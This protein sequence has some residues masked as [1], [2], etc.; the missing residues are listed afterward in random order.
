MNLGENEYKKNIPIRKTENGERNKN[1][2]IIV[3]GRKS[4][5][6]LII[7]LENRLISQWNTQEMYKGGRMRKSWVSGVEIF[8]IEVE[9]RQ[10]R[11][12]L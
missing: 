9:K 8:Y 10:C 3:T 12:G 4:I 11:C 1:E 2:S 5:N 7:N 6:H